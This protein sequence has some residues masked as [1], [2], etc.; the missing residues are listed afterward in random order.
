M[1][2]SA[3]VN[4]YNRDLCFAA[5]TAITIRLKQIND[6]VSSY[7]KLIKYLFNSLKTHI[8]SYLSFHNLLT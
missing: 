8:K 4:E 7:I 2:P 1:H 3:T 5:N 6:I